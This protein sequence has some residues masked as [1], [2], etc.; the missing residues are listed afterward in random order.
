MNAAQQKKSPS[1]KEK[2]QKNQKMEEK[3]QQLIKQ[4]MM[5]ELMQETK[6]IVENVIENEMEKGQ[7]N[8]K[9]NKNKK[10]KEK[11][12]EEKEGNKKVD[13]FI[14][15]IK[16]KKE[17]KEKEIQQENIKLLFYNKYKYAFIFD[18]TNRLKLRDETMLIDDDIINDLFS[19]ICTNTKNVDNKEIIK[20]LLIL[21]DS[22][23]EI[24]F[25]TQKNR[26]NKDGIELFLMNCI[27][28]NNQIFKDYSDE[29]KFIMIINVFYTMM[30]MKIELKKEYEN[31]FDKIYDEINKDII[32]KELEE[33]IKS[34]DKYDIR[35]NI[36][37][38]N[39]LFCFLLTEFFNK[40]EE[41]NVEYL[42]E[43][44]K[45]YSI[46]FNTKKKEQKNEI[47]QDEN[48]DLFKEKYN[49]III[50]MKLYSL[51]DIKRSNFFSLNIKVSKALVVISDKN[52]NV[53]ASARNIPNV[54]TSLVNTINTYDILKYD[55]FVVTKDNIL[56]YMK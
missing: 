42:N 19:I 12:K 30:K 50:L 5:E 51:F 20:E 16:E 52:I 46:L 10:N 13:D 39:I 41:K 3:K 23:A 14:K 31:I 24:L 37:L 2:N 35:D 25:S 17:K 9:K 15:T 45:L 47:Y 53:E 18:P 34:N 4:K 54:K 11:E 27:K 56:Q 40:K 38:I 21:L 28:F 6:K 36:K 7:K 8:K 44:I 55:M 32:F 29:N 26:E 1:K 43:L 33:N 49:S 22:F 48:L